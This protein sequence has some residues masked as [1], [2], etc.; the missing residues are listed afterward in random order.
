[1]K[2]EYRC[3]ATLADGSAM[4]SDAITLI[5]GELIDWIL[6]SEIP[7]DMDMLARAMSAKSLESMVFEGNE[8]VYVRTGESV[9]TY[10][11]ST[12]E[13]VDNRFNITVAIVDRENGMIYPIATES[14]DAE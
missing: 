2:D 7:V 12:N 10:D 6:T 5:D 13:L 1:M 3:T 9:A 14:A 4:T 11:P 8:L